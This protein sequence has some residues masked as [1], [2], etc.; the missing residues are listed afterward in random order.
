MA[1]K[2]P[3]ATADAS[4]LSVRG[5]TLPSTEIT[6][7]YKQDKKP[8]N[9]SLVPSSTELGVVGTTTPRVSSEDSFDLVSSAN[10]SVVDELEKTPKRKGDEEDGDSDWE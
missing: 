10:V 3:Q 7:I 9:E 6:H 2:T 8:M 4:T 1:S 5:T